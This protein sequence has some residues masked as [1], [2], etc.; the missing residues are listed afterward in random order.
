MKLLKTF[1]ML[2]LASLTVLLIASAASAGWFE[3]F[4]YANQAALDAVWLPQTTL[5]MAWVNDRSISPTHSLKQSTAAAGS[6]RA[7]GEEIAYAD[8]NF[9]F[10]FY[11]GGAALGRT[12]GAVY[13]RAGGEWSG[14]LQQILMIGKNNGL[15]TSKYTGR[16]VYG[17][18]SGYFNL[19]GAANRSVGWHFAEILGYPNGTVEWKID[20]VVGATR[21]PGRTETFNFVALG[22]NLSS[23]TEMWFDDVSINYVVPEPS[24]MIALGTGLIGLVGFARRRRA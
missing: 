8:L 16:M 9:S 20:G 6:R 23:S 22:S 7:I 24:S 5:P 2:F 18:G 13:S 4:E 1:K 10:W 3:N 17:T 19:D 12:W 15:V 21:T 11:D 14:G